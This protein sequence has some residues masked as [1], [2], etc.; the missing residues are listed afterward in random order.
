MTSRVNEIIIRDRHRGIADHILTARQRYSF[1]TSLDMLNVPA[2]D[3][4][5][6]PA[7]SG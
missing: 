2:F 5:T 4:V 6:Q 7:A 3:F 1:A